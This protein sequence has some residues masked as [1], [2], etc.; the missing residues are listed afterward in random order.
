MQGRAVEI[1][2]VTN[3]LTKIMHGPYYQF[4]YW[5]SI[6]INHYHFTV[7]GRSYY[8]LIYSMF[9]S[10]TTSQLTTIISGSIKIHTGSILRIPCLKTVSYSLQQGVVTC[11]HFLN[12][13]L[14]QV[15]IRKAKFCIF[16][17]AVNL[18]GSFQKL[19]L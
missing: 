6:P 2:V 13:N 7:I 16:P 17:K 15:I 12:P 1:F 8:V 3:T 11:T 4:M 9:A 19:F 5:E 10:S 14:N 18:F